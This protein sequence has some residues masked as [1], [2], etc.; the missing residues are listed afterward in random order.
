MAKNLPG[1]VIKIGANTQ[2]AISGL[3]K[4]NRAL[5]SSASR[6]DRFAAS[7]RKAAPALGLAAAAAGVLAIKL[8][9]DAVQA[10]IAEEASV[11][12]LNKALGNLGMSKASEQTSKFV[13]DLQFA[14]GVADTELRPALSS[15]A[16]ATGDMAEAQK[17][18]NIA[19]DISAQTGKPLSAVVAALS[20]GYLGNTTGL[21]RLNAGVEKNI[22][23]TGDMNKIN[24]EFARITGGAAATAADTLQGRMNILRIGVDELQ[25]SFG[26]G[27]I[28]GFMDG[29]SDGSGDLDDAT[30]ALRE[31]Q[32]TLEAWGKVIGGTLADA[33]GWLDAFGLGAMKM[34]DISAD[35]TDLVTLS[36]VNMADTLNIIS[37]EQGAAARASLKAGDAAREQAMRNYALKG[38]LDA[39]ES[40]ANGATSATDRLTTA[41]ESNANGMNKQKS[42]ADRLKASLDK[43]NNNRSIMQ[44][45]FDLAGLLQTGPGK[46]GQRKGADGKMTDFT[47]LR[48]RKEFAFT[49]ADQYANLA[50]SYKKPGRK[51][52]ALADAREAIRGMN[53]P[54]GF[55]SDLIDT[56]T[57]AR[58]TGPRAGTPQTGRDVAGV[59]YNFYGDIKVAD[60]QAARQAAKEARRLAALS[61]SRYT[62]MAETGRGY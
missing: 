55:Q 3:N 37:D 30:A 34:A 58:N 57:P 20:K 14:T 13:D 7:M 41:A 22:L 32:A 16:V 62:G 1:L 35:A 61:G 39:T 50:D 6:S 9:T 25:E 59:N 44:Q 40:A 38:S 43:L 52:G 36:W 19:L 42:A 12:K 11:S 2:D 47:T 45:K 54:A 56:L 17:A 28:Q 53:L 49:V 4:V 15:L 51:R 24:A 5:G 8:G 18:L 26:K 48:D 29:L 46:S 23:A 31:N 27:L 60:G 10:A 33:I 21:L